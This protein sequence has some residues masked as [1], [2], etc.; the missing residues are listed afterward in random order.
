MS[1]AARVYVFFPGGFGTLNEFYEIITLIQTNKIQAV[2]VICVGTE[3]W[4]SML[5]WQ[6][7]DLLAKHHTIDEADLK[8]FTITDS[9][10]L[11]LELAQFAERRD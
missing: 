11:V 5:D 3:F 10:D 7:T 2:P 8:L 4:Q 1:F 6:R 9:A